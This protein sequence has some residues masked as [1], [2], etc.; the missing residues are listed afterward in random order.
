MLERREPWEDEFFE[1]LVRNGIAA[2]KGGDRETA[3][4]LLQRA[5][6]IKMADARPW[7]WLSATTDDPEEQ[8]LYLERAVAA[9]PSNAAA[10]RGLVMLSEKLDKSRLVPEGEAV[11]PRRP[12]APETAQGMVYSCPQCGGQVQFDPLTSG[13][14]CPFCGHQQQVAAQPIGEA[15][16]QP[17][18][19]ILPTTRAHRWAEAQQSLSCERC[20]AVTIL[21]PGQQAN[22]CPFCNSNRLVTAAEAPELIQPQ[23]IGLM[24]ITEEQAYA[25]VRRWLTQG[26]LAPDDLS[27]RASQIWLRGAYYPFW[28]F[29]GTLE[30]SWRC[31]VNEGSS[32]APR[33][34]TRSGTEFAMFDDILVPGLRNLSLQEI[35][36][37]EPFQLKSLVEFSP[38]FLVGWNCLGYN[39]PLSDASLRAREKVIND[40]RKDL[41]RRVEPGREKR[42]LTSGGGKWSGLTYKHILLPLWVGSYFY[43]GKVYRL[44]V[45]GQSG[46]VGG[47]KPRDTA[48]IWMFV[49]G[50]SLIAVI[51]AIMVYVFIL[52][53]GAG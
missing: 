31:E 37:V 22:R 10:R 13:L 12:Q 48:K 35:A 21:P 8:R 51:F 28:T 42:N 34:V 24:K 27:V 15:A 17:I 16:E 14:A 4:R 18:D 53:S 41:Y 33:W 23:A 3:R 50:A 25:Q 38:E 40:L 26:W 46:K 30:I 39:L 9:D 32:R 43:R 49:V 19:F 45:N 2:V 47:K 52:R 36:A 7:L 29:D 44:L 1:T 6:R 5:S 20:G 11:A